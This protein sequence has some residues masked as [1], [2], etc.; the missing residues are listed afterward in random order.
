[1]LISGLKLGLHQ[2]AL[3]YHNDRSSSEF[4]DRTTESMKPVENLWIGDATVISVAINL[5]RSP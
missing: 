3:T 2:I 5:M 1:M 4:Y